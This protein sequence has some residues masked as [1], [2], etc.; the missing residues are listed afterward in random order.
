MSKISPQ[1]YIYGNDP[2]ST[3]PFWTDEDGS[4]GKV[5]ELTATAT[6]DDTTGTPA[7]SVT[8]TGKNNENIA[9]SFSGLKG[10][11]GATGAT[12]PQGPQ[13]EQG[14]AGET[15]TAGIS[16][17]VAS[18]GSSESG[19]LAGT[20]TGADGN[21]IN[22][23]NGAQGETGATGATGPQGPQGEQGEAGATPT[24]YVKDLTITQTDSTATFATE[25]GD[26]TIST[27]EIPIGGDDSGIVE[28]KD[29]VVANDT[30]GYDFHTFTETQNDGT[31]NEVGKFYLAQK[32]VTGIALS[33][34]STALEVTK[35]DQS[36]T[37]TSDS[38]TLPAGGNLVIAEYDGPQG[39]ITG[40]ANA[41]SFALRV[42]GAALITIS[43]TN[44]VLN[45]QD[46]IE[47]PVYTYVRYPSYSVVA[48]A[49]VEGAFIQIV[50]KVDHITDPTALTYTP[51]IIA[52]SD[53]SVT[54][55]N[56]NT[57]GAAV[58]SSTS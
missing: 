18:T 12:G 44:Y 41:T 50:I 55:G 56:F 29:T 6:V 28:V 9:F 24:D 1:G 11:T 53:G 20:I 39:E 42:W 37:E 4:S 33:S 57:R 27:V 45:Y 51:V 14:E 3:N 17:T 26:G 5:I 22:V 10:E 34:D 25:K 54:A 38:I 32:Q 2:K 46:L 8:Q 48:S 15:G 13:G 19:A 49:V 30:T 23:Y 47:V 21:M 36:G 58:F 52:V 16:P 7:V 43:G 31:E 40:V 35:V